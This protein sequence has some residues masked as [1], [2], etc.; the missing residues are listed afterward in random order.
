MP[1]MRA[2]I[3]YFTRGFLCVFVLGFEVWAPEL[4]TGCAWVQDAN[5]WWL[6][7][8]SNERMG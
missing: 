2:Y 3:Y 7:F 6:L 4:Y 1:V 8:Y 5:E